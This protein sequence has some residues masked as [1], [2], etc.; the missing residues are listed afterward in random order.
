MPAVVPHQLQ[1]PGSLAECFA[2]LAEFTLCTQTSSDVS[3]MAGEL[4]CLVP[5]V[6]ADPG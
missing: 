1:E 5:S 3:P 2:G 4:L 6:R